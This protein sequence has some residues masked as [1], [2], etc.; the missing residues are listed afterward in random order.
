M[1]AAPHFSW[2]PGFV[3]P[4]LFTLFGAAF[5]FFASQLRDDRN[6]KRAKQTF[7]RAIG[8]ELDALHKQL[9]ASLREVNDSTA[10]LARGA[11]P[12]FAG[13]LRTIVFTSQLGKLRDVSDPLMIEIVHFYSDL[14]TLQQTFE[15]V[16][17]IGV[18]Y[19]RAH[20]PSGEKEAIRPQVI[21][22]IRVLQEKISEFAGRLGQLRAKLP[23]AEEPK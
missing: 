17:D 22:G 8:M 19:N 9:D 6:A 13:A 12:R 3:I 21:S 15:I 23:P 1:Q 5:G 18:E 14:G 7:L 11:A 16:N 10:R 20:V 4:I 2:L